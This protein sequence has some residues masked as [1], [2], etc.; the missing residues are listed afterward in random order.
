MKNI[1]IKKAFVALI[2]LM[3][4]CISCGCSIKP[5]DTVYKSTDNYNVQDD[6]TESDSNKESGVKVYI[7]KTGKRYHRFGCSHAKNLYLVLS[8]DNAINK[9]YTACYYCCY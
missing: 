1:V 7:T 5:K 8:I 9:G 2:V 6:A 3:V 4:A